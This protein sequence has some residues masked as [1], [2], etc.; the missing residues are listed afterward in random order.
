MTTRETA[1]PRYPVGRYR[2]AKE[3][4]ADERAEWISD[5]EAAP[6]WFRDAVRGLSDEQLDTPYREGGWTVR[7][8]VHHIPD[9]HMNAYIRVKL[10]LTEDNPLIKTYDEAAWAALP[11]SAITPPEVS[12]AL[13]DALHVR[14]MNTL[15]SMSDGDWARTVQHPE[16]G[17]MRLDQMLGLYA[18]HGRHHAAHITRLRESRGW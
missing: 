18:W 9:S 13:L 17:P 5:V 3:I 11:E 6:A 7:Q 16:W 2:P 12:L 14:W 8:L 15:R 1:D 4:G 10:A